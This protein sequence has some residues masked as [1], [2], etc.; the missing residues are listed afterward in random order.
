[1]EVEPEAL[2]SEARGWALALWRTAHHLVGSTQDRA[3][4]KAAA[5]AKVTPNTLW[6][7]RYR[8]PREIGASVYFKLRIAHQKYVH[9]TEATVAQNLIALRALPSSPSRD[10]LVAGMEEFLRDSEGAE[11]WASATEADADFDQRE[12]WGR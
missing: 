10:R 11:A 3:M 6:K 8:P 7:L 5:M 9:S 2:V 1:M 12:G 4:R